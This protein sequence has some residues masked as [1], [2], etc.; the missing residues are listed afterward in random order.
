LPKQFRR[1]FD[2]QFNANGR[3]MMLP[4]P[5]AYDRD[6]EA[7]AISAAFCTF[8]PPS[9]KERVKARSQDQ[10]DRLLFEEERVQ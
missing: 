3:G 5:F 1:F 9:K 4:R 10:N 8:Q 6:F 7:S 2:N